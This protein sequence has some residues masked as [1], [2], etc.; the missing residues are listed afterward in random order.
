MNFDDKADDTS[1]GIISDD[2]PE[3]RTGG[4]TNLFSIMPTFPPMD[5]G[6]VD[7]VG[8]SYFRYQQSVGPGND[9]ND[10][11]NGSGTDNNN[12]SNNN[13]IYSYLAGGMG[14]PSGADDGGF[15]TALSSSMLSNANP[16][17]I[18]RRLLKTIE[19]LP[20]SLYDD[21]GTVAGSDGPG[22]KIVPIE[23]KTLVK[24]QP[25]DNEPESEFESDPDSETESESELEAKTKSQIKSE[26]EVE[27]EFEHELD[28]LAERGNTLLREG[29]TD[30]SGTTLPAP[31]S[32]ANVNAYVTTESESESESESDEHSSDQCVPTAEDVKKF[33]KKMS[34]MFSQ[35]ND[36][37]S[38]PLKKASKMHMSVLRAIRQHH[39]ELR[40]LTDP[41]IPET[42][43]QV[44]KS[45]RKETC[46]HTHVLFRQVLI[47]CIDWL[48]EIHALGTANIPY[49]SVLTT[50]L[51]ITIRGDYVQY[52][53]FVAS[54][55]VT[56][57]SNE[58]RFL[59]SC[60]YNYARY[61]LDPTFAARELNLQKL[62]ANQAFG[63]TN[64]LEIDQ[65][66]QSKMERH[67]KR[68]FKLQQLPEKRNDHWAEHG[69]VNATD[70]RFQHRFNNTLPPRGLMREN[71]ESKG[72]TLSKPVPS[73]ANSRRSSSSSSSSLSSSPSP[74]FSSKSSLSS[75]SS[76]SSSKGKKENIQLYD[77]SMLSTSPPSRSVIDE[78]IV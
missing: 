23:D 47:R 26:P 55:N 62:Q 38:S 5:T 11:G 32:V 57:L 41:Y 48:N 22:P 17:E 65:E 6:R 13:N 77:A 33:R 25:H 76:S 18:T 60:L 61:Y 29:K 4:A 58:M 3:S 7:T 45:V 2:Y 73:R 74:H 53:M 71:I 69:N 14:S 46:P 35:H 44:Y 27:P 31:R 67:E 51:A 43:K 42:L 30:D 1:V 54:N 34:D 12:N 59:L 16:L 9:N 37:S 63:Q 19:P 10:G 70:N 72:P 8:E 68:N 28:D 52:M 24:E 39:D 56:F 64:K 78:M 36:T 40:I 49:L 15:E 66:F 75:S 21:N 20:R 50:V